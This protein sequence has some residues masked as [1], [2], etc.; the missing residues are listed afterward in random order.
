MHRLPLANALILGLFAAILGFLFHQPFIWLAIGLF[1]GVFA[2]LLTDI[3]IDRSRRYGWPLRRR[4]LLLVFVEALA[5]IFLVVPA[6]GAYTTVHPERTPLLA[7]AGEINIEVEQVELVTSDGIN[8]RGWYFPSHNGAAVIA[9]HG[10]GT[11]RS[12]VIPQA[13]IMSEQGYGVLALDMRAHGESGGTIY[14][15]RLSVPDVQAGVDYLTSLPELN[16]KGIGGLGISSGAHTLLCAAAQIDA[17][18]ALILE[19]TGL[20][21]TSDAFNPLLPEIRPFLFTTPINWMYFRL[22][23][24][25]SHSKSEPSNIELVEQITPRAMFFIAAERDMFEPPLAKRYAEHGG[26]NASYW[27]VPG[28]YHAAGLQTEWEQYSQRMLAFFN[29]YLLEK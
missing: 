22:R 17:I 24:V 18:Q 15:P 3:F 5:I 2:A 11:N 27:V 16:P 6:I 14:T 10:H 20:G 7:S 26:G 28:S 23:P 4:L 12:N 21:D 8:I 1:A 9:L 29:K 19:G 25:F 13:K